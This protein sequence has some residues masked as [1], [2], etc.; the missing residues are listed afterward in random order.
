MEFD[1]HIIPSEGHLRHSC[2][3]TL[4]LKST[5]GF[6][7]NILPGV[8]DDIKRPHDNVFGFVY[9]NEAI[10]ETL[11]SAIPEYMKYPN[12]WDVL[13][14]YRKVISGSARQYFEAPRIFKPNILVGG[15]DGALIPKNADSLKY[16]YVLD[17]WI[18]EDARRPC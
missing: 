10:D 1:L 6:N 14:L 18:V 13:V 5:G 17:G 3:E 7:V 2:M 4:A 11:A 8:A 9:D 12:A 15:A 16:V